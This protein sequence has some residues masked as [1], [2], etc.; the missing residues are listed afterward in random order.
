MFLVGLTGGI[1]SGKSTVSAMLERLGAEVID[2]DLIARE[3]VEPGTQGL[4][5][6]TLAF[7]ESILNPDGSLSRETLA[8]L[9]FGN[10]ENRRILEA[11][12]HPLIKERSNGRI[13]ASTAVVVVYVVPLLVEANVD[14]PFDL[15]VT[16]ESG[17]ETQTKRLIET[18]GLS[19]EAATDRINAQATE[20]RRVERADVRLDG[21]LPLSDLEEDVSK[22]WQSI[23]SKAEQKAGNGEN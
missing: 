15:V 3:V 12:L 23:W 22:L 18:R 20:E 5:E 14:Y 16:I 4:R 6:V 1:A 11:I 19:L 17:V 7:G 2:A 8:S 21:S 10:Q 13:A 9:V